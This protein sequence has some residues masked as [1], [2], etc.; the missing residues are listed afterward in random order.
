M[1]R[2]RNREVQCGPDLPIKTN[3]PEA[4]A[5]DL[6]PEGEG[7]KI[8]HIRNSYGVEFCGLIWLSVFFVRVIQLP[9]ECYDSCIGFF[10]NVEFFLLFFYLVESAKL[11]RS[12]R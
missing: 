2:S 9:K 10:D 11:T 12:M 4:P 6:S 7:K 5:D 8:I 3:F 1:L